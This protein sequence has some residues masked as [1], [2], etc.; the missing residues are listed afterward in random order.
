[1]GTSSDKAPRPLISLLPKATG[2][3]LHFNTKQTVG[4]EFWNKKYSAYKLFYLFVLWFSKSWEMEL[5][6]ERRE[7]ENPSEDV[8]TLWKKTWKLLV[9][10]QKR[11]T[12]GWDVDKCW[13]PSALLLSKFKKR[14]KK[15]PDIKHKKYICAIS[16]KKTILYL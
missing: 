6:G 10:N 4:I 3:L 9:L 12:I 11:K 2:N 7:E 13:N 15:I 16:R 14:L 5:P 1:M 8:W